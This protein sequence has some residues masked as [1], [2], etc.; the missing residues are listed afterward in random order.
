MI[1]SGHALVY[2]YLMG[3]WSVY[4]GYNGSD[5]IIH[6]NILRTLKSYLVYSQSSTDYRV[7]AA[8]NPMKVI[9]PW[10]KV[11]GI[12]N[13]GRVYKG[14]I[15]GKFKSVH[16]LIVKTYYDYDETVF[17]TFTINPL[18]TDK[19]YQYQI[20]LSRQKCQSIKFEIYDNSTAG[21]YEGLELT[22]M[23]LIV[24]KKKGLNKINDSKAYKGA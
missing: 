7:M 12:E 15:L 1:N 16:S 3:R 21:T 4:L 13:F 24:G 19:I 11:S 9:T 8:N 14:L 23:S 2:D 22:D 17:E 20:N 18:I 5:L 6:D 10:Y